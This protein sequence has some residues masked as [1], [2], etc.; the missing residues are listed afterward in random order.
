MW[1][2]GRGLMMGWP[3]VVAIRSESRGWIQ[4]LEGLYN[5]VLNGG[6]EVKGG[7]RGK[8][9]TQPL[10]AHNRS[11]ESIYG[12]EHIYGQAHALNAGN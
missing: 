5:L 1:S 11:S 6:W 12:P 10:S 9:N 4:E 8:G 7:W 2:P 3:Q